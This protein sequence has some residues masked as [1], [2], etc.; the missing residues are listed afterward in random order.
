MF[1]FDVI[2]FD[3]G[4]VLL[5][6]G[7]DRGERAQVLEKFGVDGAAFEARHVEPYRAWE[8]GDLSVEA[9]LDATVFC[10]PRNFSRD[11]FFAAMCAN[12]KPLPNGA[13]GI[14]GE[15]AASD[16][17]MLG[18]LNNEARETNEYRFRQFGLRE[19]FRVALTSCYLGQRKPEPVMF[20]RAL[21]I[22]GR[23]AERI[24]FI[25][26]REDNAAAATDI[27]MKAIHFQG[28]DA[29]RSEL[30]MLGVL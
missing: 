16:K 20:Q 8:R 28:A 26:D 10:E 14:L 23:P 27:G 13:L 15:L 21:D 11:E 2:L 4:G 7:W 24:L 17:Y 12:S 30:E 5:T 3:V 6:N 29:L 19:Y 1:P 22:L 25:D 18:A 9:Y